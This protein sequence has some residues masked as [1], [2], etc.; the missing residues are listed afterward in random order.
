MAIS[1]MPSRIGPPSVIGKYDIREWR[2][3]YS[4]LDDAILQGTCYELHE[5][6]IWW[7]TRCYPAVLPLTMGSFAGIKHEAVGELDPP[8]SG[9]KKAK[10][11]GVATRSFHQSPY[12]ILLQVMSQ[13]YYFGEKMNTEVS[14]A[15]PEEVEALSR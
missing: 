12:L 8:T 3:R 11:S 6:K 9:G 5:L 4:L 1:T 2:K 14:A 13:L 10:S 7:L 15:I